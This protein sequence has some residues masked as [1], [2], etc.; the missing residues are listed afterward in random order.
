M[1]AELRAETPIHQR[2]RTLNG[3]ARDIQSERLEEN[4]VQRLWELTADLLNADRPAEHRQA[5]FNFYKTLIR[6][7]FEALAEMR[8]Q[9][10]RVIQEHA[11]PE[12]IGLRLDLLWMLTNEGRDITLFERDVGPFLVAWAPAIVDAHLMVM[13]LLMVS[14]MIQF[15]AACLDRTVIAGIVK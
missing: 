4:A 7:Q 14:N 13:Y 12:D 5:G 10:F 1:E 2:I 9:F 8:T 3:L 6:S 15:N 11:V